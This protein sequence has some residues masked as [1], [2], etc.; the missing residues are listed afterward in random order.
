MR[1]KSDDDDPHPEY[2]DG[3]PKSVTYAPAGVGA[4]KTA[5]NQ[6][7]YYG[8]KLWMK[9]DKH[10]KKIAQLGGLKFLDYL[11]RFY[12]ELLLTYLL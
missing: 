1:S 4:G 10:M 2:P 11:R 3:P 6:E 5:N 9:W 7:D 12:H 8:S